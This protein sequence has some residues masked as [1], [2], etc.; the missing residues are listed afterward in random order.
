MKTNPSKPPE[1]KD[2]LDTVMGYSFSTPAVDQMDPGVN[3][4]EDA[5]SNWDAVDWCAREEDVRRLRQRIFKATREQDWPRVRSLQKMMLRSWSNTLISVRQVTQRN[6]GRKTAGVDG[7]LAL[8]SSARMELAMRMHRT[9]SSWQPL[10]VQRVYI[11]KGRDNAKLRPLGIPVIMDRCHQARVRAA[12]EPEW[13]ARFEP[14]SYGFR[15][16]RSCADAIASLF[17]I[18]RGKAAKRVWI[19]DADLT[20]AFDRIDHSRLLARIGS[21]PARNMIRDWLKAGVFEPERGFAPTEEGTPQGGVISPLLLNVALHGLEEAAGVRYHDSGAHTDRTISGC[22]AVVRYADDL[23]A[24]CHSKQQAQQ[25]KAQLAEWL[26]PRGLTFNEDKTAIVHLERDGFD[27]LGFNVRRYQ[28]GKLLIKPS[29]A[30][31]RR[32]RERLADEMRGLRGSNAMAVIARLNPIIRGWSTYYRGVV[33]SKT[34][35]SLDLHVWKLTYKWAK[36]THPNKSKYWICDR[37][38]GKFNKFR[39]DRWVFGARDRVDDHGAVPHLSRFSWTD[40]VR[41]RLVQGTASPDDPHLASYWAARRRRVKPPLDNYTLRLLDR[42]SGHCPLCTDPL[43]TED[44]PP[45]SPREWERWWLSIARK[46]IAHDYLVHD[47]Q[48]GKRGRSDKDPTRLVHA[49]CRRQIGKR[50][51]PSTSTPHALVAA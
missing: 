22:P 23:V 40:I 15:P 42:Q 16:G 35:Q 19:L 36:H 21:F 4:P 18:L 3:G 29:T 2:K 47:D 8:T 45:Q 25:V 20:A 48:P 30:A 24:C 10:P 46:A 28:Q 9:R 38:F 6:A 41:H 11:P 44:Q 34:F 26:A 7:E 14:R 51:K 31:V 39:N 5:A 27:F 33:S 37:Y 13:E 43:L 50:R 1:P 12:L 17:T 32:L 49:S